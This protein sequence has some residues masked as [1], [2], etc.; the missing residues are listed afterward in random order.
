[1]VWCL[2]E[3]VW[4]SRQTSAR[5]GTL[6][7]FGPLGL[8][9]GLVPFLAPT[10]AWSAGDALLAAEMAL[11]GVVSCSIGWRAYLR[12]ARVHP[13]RVLAS[14]LR[15]T[16][17]SRRGQRA[18]SRLFLL[19]MLLAVAGSLGELI[20]MA[21][22]LKA[23]LLAGRF[24]YRGEGN[25]LLRVLFVHVVTN[26][27][28][29][30]G[31][32]GFFLPR[33]YRIAGVLFSVVFA[34]F[35]FWAS[36]GG[37]GPALGL[38][39]SVALGFVL[40]RRLSRMQ[41]IFL[42]AS[43]LC[44]VLVAAGLYKVRKSMARESALRSVRLL[45][46]GQTYIDILERD[47]LNYH[48]VLV[49]AVAVFPRRHAYL[50]GATYVRILF[51]PVPRALSGGLKP[52]DTHLVFAEAIGV[53]KRGVTV[54]PTLMG[55]G[56]INFRGWPGVIVVLMGHGFLYAFLTHRMRQSLLLFLVVAATFG[57]VAVMTVRGQPYE[58]VAGLVS[59][60]ILIFPAALLSGFPL[61]WLLLRSK[62]RATGHRRQR[63]P[64][65]PDAVPPEPL[66]G[67]DD[68]APFRA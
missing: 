22:S 28:Q 26:F 42:G 30:P 23:A 15:A 50:N 60:G 47:P 31:F 8:I 43:L 41:T 16:L 3:C 20:A 25:L 45:A 13:T 68:R 17:Q 12:L 49:S 14:D 11:L 5:I 40:S 2:A 63:A 53:R 39:V 46:E 36:K 10:R 57:H 27:A 61:R 67:Q 51:A 4:A 66:A 48:S 18:L 6:L 1:M 19:S 29:L 37:R 65:N 56:Y 64:T 34:A 7:L 62:P 44:L 38:V 32:L 21:G 58:I 24:E 52:R 33:R 55:D 35:L 54:P 59:G 9:H